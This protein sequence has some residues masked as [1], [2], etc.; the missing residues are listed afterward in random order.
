[1]TGKGRQFYAR[2]R[3]SPSCC[4]GENLKDNL[5]IYC[6]IETLMNGE[7]MSSISSPFQWSDTLFRRHEAVAR[8]MWQAMLLL[9]SRRR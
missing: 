4:S 9:R 3:I 8:T 7:E 2:E 1:M 5:F 6:N